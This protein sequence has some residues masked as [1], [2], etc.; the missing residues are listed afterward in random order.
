MFKTKPHPDGTVERHK[1]RLVAKV[2]TQIEG[3]DYVE[4]YSPV[5]KCVTVRLLLALVVAKDW[6]LHQLDVN[7]AFL[8]GYLQEDVFMLPPPGYSV[9]K[10]QVCKLVR[11]C[12]V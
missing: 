10:G 3:M 6:V 5:A 8:H 7:N 4:S 11:S 12:M 9:Q 2:F 1:A